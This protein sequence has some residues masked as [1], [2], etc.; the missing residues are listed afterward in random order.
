MLLLAAI[1]LI[2]IIVSATAVWL[3]RRISGWQ[4]FNRALVG[5]P[6][7]TDR[8][9]IGLQQGFIS[10]FASPRKRA[11]NMKL[12]SPRGGIKAPWGW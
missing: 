7:L 10:M 3:Y 9:K 4:G 6:Q 8:T 5:R 12:R 11:K 2:T 1:F